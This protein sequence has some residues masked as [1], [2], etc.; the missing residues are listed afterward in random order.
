MNEPGKFSRIFSFPNPVNEFAARWVAAMVLVLSLATII[1]GELWLLAFLTYGFVARVATG[2]TLSP[3]GLIATRVLIPLTGNNN[4]PTA[5]PPKRFAQT[6]GLV[7]S[8]TALTLYFAVDSATPYRAL[9]GTL[10]IF[11]ALECI[12]GFCAGCFM[13]GWLM[14]WGV[15]PESVCQA[16]LE[17]LPETA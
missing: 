7:F 5:G 8:V 15:I 17:Y 16:C 9:L 2:P 1:S 11:A 3:I 4:R 13:F 14:R 12:V 10:S 6:I